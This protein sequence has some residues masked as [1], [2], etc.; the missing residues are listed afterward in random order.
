[1]GK[2]NLSLLYLYNHNPKLPGVNKK[3]YSK[4]RI[5]NAS[6]LSV[7]GIII[8]DG[9][10]EVIFDKENNLK[11]IPY[12][13][14][15]KSP[16]LKFKFL[17]PWLNQ[18][19]MIRHYKKLIEVI[20]QEKKIDFIIMRYSL[21]NKGLL[22]FVNSFPGK[23]IFENNTKELE[24]FEIKLKKHPSEWNQ[25]EYN[26]E[27][28]YAPLVLQ[29]A[30]GIIGVTNEICNY[31]IER[32]GIDPNKSYCLPNG[33]DVNSVPLRKVPE[34]DGKYLNLLFLAGSANEWHGIDRIIKGIASY[35]GE[36]KIQLNIVGNVLADHKKLV[37]DL[38]L[39]EKVKFL[40]L[41]FDAA[42]DALFDE[43]H[44]AFGSMAMHRV[45]LKEACV[46]KV[47]EYISRGIPFVISY[48]DTD[49]MGEE[50]MKP[51]Y[52]Q[53]PQSEEEIDIQKVIDFS[54]KVYADN[55]HHKT[56]RDFAIN[57]IDHRAKMEKFKT[58][59]SR[60]KS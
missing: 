14:P 33:F 8:D 11:R 50:N 2:E 24:Q 30:A 9:L 48:E 53:I 44:I 54:V 40:P 27:L 38:K 5:M 47:R 26:S 1:M 18:Q 60:L 7:R 57:K 55:Q 17:W 36:V 45:Q 15:K 16:L 12:S 6:G 25:L 28:K 23:I 31:E 58:F 56:L 10:K 29:K 46:L 21:A 52:L 49:L 3:V 51:Y 35:N 59:L 13:A 39:N 41:Q 32:S 34:F 22:H 4:I 19:F 20:N 42:L 37:E 43:Q